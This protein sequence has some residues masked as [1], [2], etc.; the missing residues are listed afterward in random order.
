M[1]VGFV[2]LLKSATLHPF[3]DKK[4]LHLQ[5]VINVVLVTAPFL[6]ADVYS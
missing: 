1:Q 3:N 5:T 6:Q 2:C 4:T